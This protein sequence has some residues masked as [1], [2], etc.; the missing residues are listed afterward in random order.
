CCKYQPLTDDDNNPTDFN[1]GKTNIANP[2][3]CRQIITSP[4]EIDYRKT[5]PNPSRLDNN[6]NNNNGNNK[7][8]RV[9]LQHHSPLQ[10]SLNNH[11]KRC[12]DPPTTR[13]N[14]NIN[15]HTRNPRNNN[16]N[17]SNKFPLRRRTQ[18][19]KRSS[20]RACVLLVYRKPGQD[21]KEGKGHTTTTTN[22]NNNNKNNNNT[23][24]I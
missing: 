20:G 15:S 6:N 14:K 12:R 17:N 8:I 9:Q 11:H 19:Q 10:N 7:N 13:G 22:N 16:K 4:T 3:R 18:S 2:Q 21:N 23:G 5:F 1:E 24:K